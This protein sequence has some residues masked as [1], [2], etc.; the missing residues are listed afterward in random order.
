MRH[1][2]P[3]ALYICGSINQT[4]QMHKIAEQLPELDGYFT[5]FYTDN[6]FLVAS[7][8]LQMQE[9]N[10]MGNRARNRCRDYLRDHGL[11]I[12]YHGHA[13]EVDY[14]LVVASTDLLIPHNV[15][16]KPIVAVQEGILDRPN[17]MTEVCRKVPFV[18]LWLGGT[19]LTGLSGWYQ[20]F[21]V[22]SEGYRQHF[23]KE[24]ADPARV[25]ATGIPNFD[26]CL[27]YHENDFPHHG[28]V[29]VCTSDARETFKKDDRR[30]LIER[31]A[32]IADGRQLIFKLHPMENVQRATA[33]VDAWAPG[34]L[35]YSSGSAEEMIANCD[36]LI[37]QWS[38]VAFVGV[39]LGKEVHSYFP[40]EELHR[41]LPLQNGGTSAKAIA[42]VCR[43][44]H[45]RGRLPVP[46]DRPWFL[47]LGTSRPSTASL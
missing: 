45:S 15:R 1:Q 5:P 46:A 10:I 3:K 19:A 35:V 9:W 31:A 13:H 37:T 33:E 2:K 21:C 25:V 47:R 40:D 23:I 17:A 44:V 27:E 39:A 16:S 18:P 29:L 11:R 14:E 42:D 30:G 28:Y 26:N 43:Q 7:R 8:R 24:G 36:V 34:S 22:A 32:K 20:K 4:K 38:S 6:P 12:D 41:L